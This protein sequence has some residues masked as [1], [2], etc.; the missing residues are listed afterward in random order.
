MGSLH[1]DSCLPCVPNSKGFDYKISSVKQSKAFSPIS[2]KC[3]ERLLDV[4]D[5]DNTTKYWMHTLRKSNCCAKDISNILMNSKRKYAAIKI[6]KMYIS[7]KRNMISKA[8]DRN[9]TNN[10]DGAHISLNSQ[11]EDAQSVKK[12][13]VTFKVTINRSQNSKVMTQKS[14][15]HSF[16]VLKLENREIIGVLDS[17]APN[18]LNGVYIVKYPSSK[19]NYKGKI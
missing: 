8:L 13:T 14:N 2:K 17:T 15:N 1:S 6:Q 9:S 4:I 5:F 18:S 7:Y 10:T 19:T 11:N 3:K 16:Q 12:K